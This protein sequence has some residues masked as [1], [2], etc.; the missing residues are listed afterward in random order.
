[1][2][3]GELMMLMCTYA[4]AVLHKD[5]VQQ[6]LFTGVYEAIRKRRNNASQIFHNQ[7][8]LLWFSFSQ[9]KFLVSKNQCKSI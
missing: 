6:G 7:T 9:F 1:M 3:S 8:N 5:D 2:L 4:Y